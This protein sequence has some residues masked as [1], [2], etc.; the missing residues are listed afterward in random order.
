MILIQF[1]LVDINVLRDVPSLLVMK[2][3]N[4]EIN[5]RRSISLDPKINM[6]LAAGV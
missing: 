3:T 1:R 4:E 5:G 2:V 6:R